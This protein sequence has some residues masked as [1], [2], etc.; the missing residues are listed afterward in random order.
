MNSDFAIITKLCLD[1][2]YLDPFQGHRALDVIAP[3]LQT[4]FASVY[5]LS[6]FSVISTFISSVKAYIAF[7][8]FFVKEY[9]EVHWKAENK[10]AQVTVY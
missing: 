1:G 9:V 2:S 6:K 3:G 10:R 8:V 5:T 4:P 7:H